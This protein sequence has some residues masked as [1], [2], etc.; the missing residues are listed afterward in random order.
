MLIPNIFYDVVMNR[1]PKVR[2]SVQERRREGQT[3]EFIVHNM[4]LVTKLTSYM[5]NSIK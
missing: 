2:R 5:Y 3:N 4:R 1:P